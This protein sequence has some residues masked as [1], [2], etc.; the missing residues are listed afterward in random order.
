MSEDFGTGNN[1]I[2]LASKRKQAQQIVEEAKE[3][4]RMQAMAIASLSNKINGEFTKA[5]KLI[6]NT[7]GHLIVCGIGKSGLIGQKM[8][9]TF[10]ST[11]TPSFFVHPAEAY[12]GD[13]GMITEEDVIL[14]ISNS[15][16]TEEVVRL[17]PYLKQLSVPIIALVGRQDSH[18]ATH[19]DVCIDISV[20]REVCPNNLAPT[21]STL[22]TLAMGDAM[23]VSLIKEKNFQANDF[24]RLHPGG[25]LGRKLLTEVRDVMHTG[26]LPVVSPEQ[27]VQ[28][29]LLPMTQGRLG[30][31]L[32]M[33]QDKLLGIVTDGDLRRALHKYSDLSKVT[34]DSI[35]TSTPKTICETARLSD[36]EEIMKQNKIKALVV[37]DNG[38]KVSGILE[39]FDD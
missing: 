16:E 19:A 22:A 3:V 23:A 37:L 9:A 31:V 5:V 18:L 12:H 30:L 39:I 35:M 2:S 6:L 21:N 38:G 33:E 34:V 7:T 32:V 36:A 28:D 25:S 14:L 15:G 8:A 11:G 4:F 13:L 10:A 17:I 20:D 24:A 1:V 26:A 29:S 27:S